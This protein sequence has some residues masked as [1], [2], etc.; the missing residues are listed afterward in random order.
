M[1]VL[2]ILAP[3]S[4]T[5]FTLLATP[6]WPGSGHQ[7]LSFLVYHSS[8]QTCLPISSVS[9]SMHPPNHSQITFVILSIKN[10]LEHKLLIG[11]IP[12]SKLA[13]H[14]QS[15]LAP[16]PSIITFQHHLATTPIC[17]MSHYF[18]LKHALDVFSLPWDHEV[19][20]VWNSPS[21]FRIQ[22]HI[23]AP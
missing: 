21:S 9:P 11:Q 12:N 4:F 22:L 16:I 10:F 20:S 19:S 8:F 23:P 2:A 5:N 13:W 18:S 17:R 14:S 7:R 3:K 6:P 15:S 1:P